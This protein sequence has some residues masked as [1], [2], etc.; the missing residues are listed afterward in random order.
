MPYYVDWAATDSLGGCLM[1]I[2][3]FGLIILAMGLV[4]FIFFQLPT[5]L[6][7]HYFD[8]SEEVLQKVE[9]FTNVRTHIPNPIR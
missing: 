1:M 3:V 5:I 9:V 2:L 8:D 4:L 6:I 7:N